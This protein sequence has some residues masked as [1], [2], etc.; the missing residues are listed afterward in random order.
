M[1]HKLPIIVIVLLSLTAAGCGSSGPSRAPVRGQVRVAGQPLKRGR[2][3][4]APLAPNVGPTASA[5]VVDGQYQL[6]TQ[7]GA[8]WE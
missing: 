1:P 2:I 4:F 3:L 6:P 5:V 7:E 8:A